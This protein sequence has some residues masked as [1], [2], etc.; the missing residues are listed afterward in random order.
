MVVVLMPRDDVLGLLPYEMA[1]SREENH[2]VFCAQVGE[3][4]YDHYLVVSAA[5]AT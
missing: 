1:V 4:E 3:E 2:L 5:T